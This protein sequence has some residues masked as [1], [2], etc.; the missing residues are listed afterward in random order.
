MQ[1]PLQWLLMIWEST[2]AT[3]PEERGEEEENWLLALNKN[4]N[5]YN[6]YVGMRAECLATK[7]MHRKL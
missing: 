2:S 4:S 5:M 3:I 7:T 1:W 6:V